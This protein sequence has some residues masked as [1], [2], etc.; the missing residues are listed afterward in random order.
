M[1]KRSS[2][3]V[4]TAVSLGCKPHDVLPSIVCH[5]VPKPVAVHGCQHGNRRAPRHF[6]KH[7]PMA[8]KHEGFNTVYLISFPRF[9]MFNVG[10]F[11][12][13]IDWI[14]TRY[15]IC[16]SVNVSPFILVHIPVP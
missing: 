3:M 13:Y 10:K 2:R 4:I 1:D 11:I 5:M 12:P 16:L 14:H 9:L 8:W 6:G 15:P 7:V